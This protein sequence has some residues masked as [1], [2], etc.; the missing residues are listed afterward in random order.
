MNHVK[1]GPERPKGEPRRGL[2]T[3]I[4][5][6]LL[7]HTALIAECSKTHDSGVVEEGWAVQVDSLQSAFCFGWWFFPKES[8][9]PMKEGV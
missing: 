2:Y 6:E 1:V 4:R 3:G 8:W 5:K 7:G 9:R